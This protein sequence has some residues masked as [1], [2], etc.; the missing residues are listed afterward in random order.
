MLTLFELFGAIFLYIWCGNSVSTPH[1]LALHP[2]FYYSDNL[3]WAAQNL[4]L[5]RL[6]A[7]GWT[8]LI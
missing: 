1:F 7:A 2:W 6:Q 5:G 3:N 4:R 8:Q